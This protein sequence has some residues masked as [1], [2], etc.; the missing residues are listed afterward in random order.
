MLLYGRGKLKVVWHSG[1]LSQILEKGLQR[2]GVVSMNSVRLTIGYAGQHSSILFQHIPVDNIF[3]LATHGSES[4]NDKN[5]LSE[6]ERHY[7]PSE[8]PLAT[9]QYPHDS[10]LSS[11]LS[12]TKVAEV[13]CEDPSGR[14]G[15]WKGI[16][17]LTLAVMPTT[18]PTFSL[19][20]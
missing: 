14:E 1:S 2:Y 9:Q 7:H 12:I 4:M 16:P 11:H 6:G 15:E 19:Q 13:G 3:S 10:Q 20:I 5:L 18:R 17:I 8:G